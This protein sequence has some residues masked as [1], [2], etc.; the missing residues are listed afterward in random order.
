MP[1]KL[2]RKILDILDECKNYCIKRQIKK[3]SN[4]YKK[5]YIYNHCHYNILFLILNS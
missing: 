1:V 3:G 2:R 4:Q 5:I